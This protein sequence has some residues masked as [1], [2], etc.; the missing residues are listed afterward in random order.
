MAE[1]ITLKGVEDI[2]YNGEKTGDFQLICPER[3]GD[4]HRLPKWWD[5]TANNKDYLNC[6]VLAVGGYH[7]V[8]GTQMQSEVRIIWDGT[9]LSFPFWKGIQRG[10]LCSPGDYGA[11]GVINDYIFP[12][13]PGGKVGVKAGPSTGEWLGIADPNE[14]PLESFRP[15]ANGTYQFEA[16]QTISIS[17]GVTGNYVGVGYR[18]S[19]DDPDDIIENQGGEVSSYKG[20]TFSN[21]L[22]IHTFTQTAFKPATPEYAEQGNPGAQ[23]SPLI[24]T[25]E[26]E[27][28]APAPTIGNVTIVGNATPPDGVQQTYLCEYDG[29]ATDV[30]YLWNISGNISMNSI[31]DG[32]IAVTCTTGSS[33]VSCTVSS[34]TA[35][36]STQTGALDITVT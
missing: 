29:N 17:M 13:H 7:L 2:L 20:I 18:L 25:V 8:L 11:S 30:S 12:N 15:F 31:A 1:D 6:T 35:S 33:R 23:D 4:V 22:G 26:I 27:V 5:V 28:V 3:S 36:D 32:Q 21:N 19:S 9:E 16:G 34:P 24:E 10:M 14:A